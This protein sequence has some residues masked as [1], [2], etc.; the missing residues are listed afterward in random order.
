MSGQLEYKGYIG[1]IDYTP[2][3][4]VLF[5]KVI[6]IKGL[7]SYEGDSLLTIKK[8]FMDA[9]DDYL[10]MCETEGIEPEKPMATFNV[11]RTA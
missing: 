5:G 8:D 3:D 7:V 11:A 4:D 2:E 9:V 6:G 1:T 10:E